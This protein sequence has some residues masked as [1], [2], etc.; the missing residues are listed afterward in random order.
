VGG[1]RDREDDIW[2]G[3]RKG[4]EFRTV[5]PSRAV[6]NFGSGRGKIGQQTETRRL[7]EAYCTFET[8]CKKM[9]GLRCS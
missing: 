4:E 5:D 3:K 2:K 9:V 7:K 8:A 6:N 1:E